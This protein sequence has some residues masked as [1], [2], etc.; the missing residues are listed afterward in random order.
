MRRRE[1]LAGLVLTITV[2][3]VQSRQTGNVYRVAI[4]GPAEE[5]RFSQMADASSMFV[6]DQVRVP[7][8]DAR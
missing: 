5:P 3:G 6:G 7:R 8:P 1:F 4:L 2:P